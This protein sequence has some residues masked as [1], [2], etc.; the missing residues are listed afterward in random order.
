MPLSK[1]VS[2][3]CGDDL[4]DKVLASY[5][6]DLNSNPQNF[7]LSCYCNHKAEAA[8]EIPRKSELPWRGQ[9]WP[10]ACLYKGILVSL[11]VGDVLSGTSNSTTHCQ[12]I[13]RCF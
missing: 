10:T 2:R 4:V 12:F 11:P 13:G 3:C 8:G 1:F 5:A 9:E 7:L 6:W